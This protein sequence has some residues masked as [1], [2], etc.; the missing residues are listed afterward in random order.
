MVITK[1]VSTYEVRMLSGF[2]NEIATVYL[3]ETGPTPN[4]GYIGYA[5]FI[6]DGHPLPAN[7][8]WSNGVLNIYFPLTAMVPLLDT[9]RNE[10]PVFVRYNTDLNWGSIGTTAEA[11]GEQEPQLIP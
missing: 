8:R 9:L 1:E 10:R 11:V 6:K 5:S 2:G 4:A 3:N 7:V